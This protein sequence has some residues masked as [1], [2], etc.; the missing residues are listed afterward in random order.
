[1]GRGGG[2]LEDLWAFNEELVAR[3]VA[4]SAIPVVSAVGHETDVSLCDFVADLRAPTPSAAAELVVA[5]K[6]E[7][8]ALV[9]RQARAL[10]AALQ[11]RTAELH[12]RLAEARAADFLRQPER[13]VERLAQ[14]VDLLA[15]RLGHEAQQRVQLR[16]KL[17]EQVFNRLSL[18]RARQGRRV[19]ARVLMAGQSLTRAGLLRVERLRARVAAYERQLEL[20]SPLAVLERGYSLTRTAEGK[21]VR[22]VSDV[23]AGDRLVTRVKDGSFNSVAE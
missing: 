22:A 13:A 18:L 7:L 2:S 15:M 10:R 4:A 9:A 11:Q 23:T 19:E 12:G 3:A 17:A 21:L 20:L 6:V 5:P 8:E 14:R 1:V 16:R